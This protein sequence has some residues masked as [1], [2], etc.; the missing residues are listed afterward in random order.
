[1]KI[2]NMLNRSIL[3]IDDAVNILTK[4]Y[5][6]YGTEK[7]KKLA[8]N[9][10][11]MEQKIVTELTRLK[12]TNAGSAEFNGFLRNKLKLIFDWTKC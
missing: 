6:E 7:Q 1:M 10:N 4:I 11:K 3:N 9:R 2:E 5:L 8:R 12:K